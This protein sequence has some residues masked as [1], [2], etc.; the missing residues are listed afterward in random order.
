M[1]HLLPSW[2]LHPV[3]TKIRNKIFGPNFFVVESQPNKHIIENSGSLWWH[4]SSS[5]ARIQKMPYACC[6]F[7]AGQDT[8]TSSDSAPQISLWVLAFIGAVVAF[9]STWA[10]LQASISTSKQV[11]DTLRCPFFSPAA[12]YR[13]MPQAPDSIIEHAFRSS[14]KAAK[15]AIC[16]ELLRWD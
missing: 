10:M 1:V 12:W 9:E 6:S 14:F 15:P 11:Q 8:S 16:H 13:Q 2:L 5:T 3:S 7:R 4:L